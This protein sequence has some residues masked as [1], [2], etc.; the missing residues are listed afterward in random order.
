MTLIPHPFTIARMAR[1]ARSFGNFQT[2]ANGQVMA[3]IGKT[4]AHSFEVGPGS[5]CRHLVSPP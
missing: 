3:L 4:V 2:K 5:H 1:P